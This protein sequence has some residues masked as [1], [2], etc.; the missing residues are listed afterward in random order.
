[1]RV[2]LI[3]LAVALLVAG[4]GGRPAAQQPAQQQPA[5]QA[6]APSGEEVKVKLSEFQF[7]PAT[8]EVK[9]GK[10]GFE[11]E[12]AGTVEHSFVITD[13]NKGT[14]QIRPGEE[15]KFEADL[16]PGTYTVI[17]DVAGHKEAGM[18]MK[19]VVK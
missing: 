2:V 7:A 4:C 6:A 3:A 15:R 13:L 14:E 10:V 11:L 8:V 9:A 12:N 16:K 17:C 19:L 5:P 18:V 1:M